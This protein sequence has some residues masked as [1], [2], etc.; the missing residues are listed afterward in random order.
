M[1]SQLIS[2]IE[3]FAKRYCKDEFIKQELEDHK[4]WE[5]HTQLVR[6]YSLILAEIEWAEKFVVEVASLLHDIGKFKWREWHSERSYELSK[7]FLWKLDISSDKLNLILNCIRFHWSKHSQE[8]HELEV[9]VVQCAD[10]L[11]TFF[12]EEW[13]EYSRKTMDKSLLLRLFD[14]SYNKLNLDS[15]KS[16]AKP[17]VDKLRNIVLWIT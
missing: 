17:Q 8:N 4:L 12:D 5:N 3:E 14:K 1:S 10:A 9:K 11:W 6:K 15:A 13:Q 2:I 16:I 7:G